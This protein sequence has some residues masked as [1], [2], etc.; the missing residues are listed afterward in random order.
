MSSM[1]AL[2]MCMEITACVDTRLETAAHLVRQS[3]QPPVYGYRQ[4][5]AI[6]STFCPRIGN[7]I[8]ETLNIVQFYNELGCIS[9]LGK[10]QGRSRAVLHSPTPAPR[11]LYPEKYRSASRKRSSRSSGA[12]RGMF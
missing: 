4:K 8:P 6:I 10:I 12:S 1:V 5:P 9:N 11:T 3:N 7:I 2:E